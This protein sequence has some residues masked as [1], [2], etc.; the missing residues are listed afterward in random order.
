MIITI[1]KETSGESRAQLMALLCRI[2]G[3]KRPITSTHMREREVIAI[4]SALIDAQAQT[5]LQAQS[6]VEQ[7]HS[8]KTPYQLVSR[9][10][11][12]EDTSITIGATNDCTPIT[13]GGASAQPV[14]MAGPC[15]VENREQLI[16]TAQAVKRAG[17]QVLRGGA[18][19]PRTSPYQF[20][21]LGVEGL[22][23]LAEART[24]TGLPVITEVMEPGMV[25][26]VAQYA[27]ILQIGARNV[28][29]FP[30]LSAVGRHS[31]QLPVLLKRGLASTIDEWLLAAEYIIASGNPN[32]ILCERGI[33]SYDPQ[34]RNVLDLS[35]VPLIH[36]LT[37]LPIIVDPSHS[38]GRRELVPI[39]S[40]ASI[41]AEAQGLIIEVHPDPDTA[42]CDGKQSITPDQ[43]EK[44][45]RETA[46]LAHMMRE[47]VSV[48]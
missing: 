6:A 3:S 7:I 20:Q 11:Q 2:T 1:R 15:A 46:L 30:L 48:A 4:D 31:K 43:L 5:T 26:T 32:V 18:F 40:R 17:A 19:K 14:I 12:T 8:L 34:T 45:V 28:Q 13:I 33:R 38:T 29:N 16:T 37:H 21:G 27:D 39:M 47:E 24:L 36:Q 41:A 9:A 23:L 10:F 42:L 25:E 44:I 22:H 35:C